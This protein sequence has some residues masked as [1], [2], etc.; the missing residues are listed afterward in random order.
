MIDP[1]LLEYASTDRQREV[2]QAVIDHGGQSAAARA[3][4]LA[5]NAVDEKVAIAKKRA[6][7]HGWSPA[8]GL[9]EPYPDPYYM[10]KNTIQR[11]SEGNIERTW[12]RMVFSRERQAEL[13]QAAYQAM[14]SELPQ[15]SPIPKP[16]AAYT[17]LCNAYIL[18]DYHLGMLAWHEET[19][20]DWDTSI[21]EDLL[22]RWF[23]TAIRSAPAAHTGV[24]AQ[25]GDLLHHDGLE[26]ITPANRNVLDADTRF[27][28]IVRVAIRSL[29]RVV[30]MLL[31]KHQQ[32]HIIMA[33]GNHDPASSVW[34]REWMAEIYAE[35]PRV[36]VDVSADPYYCFEW[37]KTSLFFHH[38][39]LKK[40]DSIDAVFAAKFRDVF[41]R[42]KYSYGHM[43]HLHHNRVLESALMIV[44][45]HPTLASR[46]A[47]AS[48]HGYSATRSASAITYHKDTGY[49]GEVSITPEM[50]RGAA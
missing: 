50:L 27:G 44:R 4:G 31:E 40:P 2:L 9:R 41:G 15:E 36:T 42:T 48:R 21:A 12:E 25:I 19:G 20:E 30:R 8:H 22:T 37:G 6:T 46:D 18:T 11:D 28:K 13:M 38:G 10:G 39:H 35:E 24:L 26:S 16:Q 43:G 1:K 33:E 7:A 47:Y 23:A 17:A 5:K 32:V 14:A 3:L 34:L 49:A 45:Q 29:R